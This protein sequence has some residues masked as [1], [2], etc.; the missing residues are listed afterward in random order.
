MDANIVGGKVGSVGAYDVKFVGGQLAAEL[1]VEEGPFA[2]NLSVK[3]DAGK[4]LDAIADAVP[5][6]IDDAVIALIKAA[7]L[8]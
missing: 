5:G 7:L 4:V 1:V 2:G 6:Q 8:K 3:I